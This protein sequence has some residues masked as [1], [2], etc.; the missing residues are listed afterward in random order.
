MT[1]RER[2]LCCELFGQPEVLTS[3]THYRVALEREGIPGGAHML[4]LHIFDA[5][6]LFVLHALHLMQLLDIGA[7]EE[8]RW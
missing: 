4:P 5:R 7:G 1:E 6:D 3:A 8:P 2:P